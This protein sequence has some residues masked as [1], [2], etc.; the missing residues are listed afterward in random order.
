MGWDHEVDL[1]VVG[2][3]AA[4]H[5]AAIRA[6]DLGLR[7]L[8]LEGSPLVG[9]ST[10]MSGGV[11]WIPLNPQMQARGISDS[12]EEALAYLRSI[13]GEGVV[14]EDRLVAYV[15]HA[16]R[17]LAYLQEQ[18][19]FRL[20]SLEKYADYYAENPGGKPGGRSMEP[21]PFDASLLGPAFAH[22]RPPHP[23]SQVMGR[24]GLTARD[25]HDIL[26]NDLR[27]KWRLIRYAFSYLARWFTR[28]RFHRDTR[29]TA[30]NALIGRLHRSLLDRGVELW[31]EAPA[32]ELVMEG[33][34]AVGVRCTVQG[35]ERAVG[36]RRGVLLAAGGFERDQ[37]MRDAHQRRPIDVAWSA[38]SPASLGAGLRM[39]EAV[40]AELALLREAWW[41]PVTQ[42]PR[43]ELA[44]VLVVEKSLPGGF[45][46]NAEGRRFTNEAAPYQDVVLAMYEHGAVPTCWLVFDAEFRRL[47]PVGPVAPGY[48]M[49]DRSL[50]RK[51]REGFFR[52]APSIEG[53]AEKIGVPVDT[54][55]A[56][57]QRFNEQAER[58]V[59]E[60]FGRGDKLA[61]RY[62][63]D[64][65]V[66][67]NPCLRALSKAPFYAIPVFA[68][69]LGTKGGLVT[70][71]AARVLRP[72]GSVIEGLFAAGNTSA[73]V[74][75]M[76]YPGAG[77]TI[78]P[79]LVFGFLAAEAAASEGGG[80]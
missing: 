71:A 78:G 75:G 16:A 79:A 66:Q 42:V 31:R 65:N 58:G 43:S 32:T 22:L 25:A 80:R 17:V 20:D 61:D 35:V 23:Q 76:S 77:G 48:A 36:A 6:H 1:V 9:G 38:A 13:V 2:S 7:V 40:G 51:F 39:G 28:R 27:G 47:Y 10:A 60:D 46:V 21:V 44:W 59:D 45:M 63:G 15:D 52:V 24:F 4:G 67:P 30:G 69:D 33:G 68:G 72:D 53:L 41:T 50:S 49:P 73:A 5:A 12:R 34:R 62:Y 55:T 57:V 18:T 37:A 26:R 8:V 54:F 29:L 3:G 64:V 11:V 14:A 19:H 56:T 70:D 74:M